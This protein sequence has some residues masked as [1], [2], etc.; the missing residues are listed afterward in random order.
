VLA[1]QVAWS[2]GIENPF[3]SLFL[4]PMALGVLALPMRW[5]A[6]I[7]VAC[8]LGY[9]ASV[10]FARDLPHLHQLEGGGFA[11]HKLGMFVNFMVSAA[12]LLSFFARM[13]VA[14]RAKDR[15]MAQLREQFARDEGIVALATHAASV[16]HEL[17]TPL[18]TLT[19]MVEELEHG[20]GTP[21][22]LEDY[23]TL[24]SLLEVCRE[25]VMELA[26]PAAGSTDSSGRPLVNLEQVI[27][28]WRR[29]RPTIDLQRSGDIAGREEVDPS[30]GYLLQALLN[31]AADAVEKAGTRRV[32][33]RLEFAD[34]GLRGEIRDY[35][36]GFDIGRPPLPATLFRTDKPRG[37]GIGLALSH[38][39]VQRLGGELSMAA[40][41][42][43]PGVLVSF[44]VPAA[45]T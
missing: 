2:G 39:T 14:S 11:L 32:D 6:V 27:D 16:A 4:L 45:L 24:R 12:V 19:L 36:K 17:N 8:A 37:L 40:P 25:R 7:A 42:Q 33:L 15:E 30:I 18:A 23:A 1:W 26:S 10:L 44:H 21:Q 5:S 20:G 35:G 22:Q 34:G 43:G 28:R 13:A 41:K 31:N 3:S 38:A 29:I 9:G